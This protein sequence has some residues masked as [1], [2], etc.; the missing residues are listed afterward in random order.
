MSA[1][2]SSKNLVVQ[3]AVCRE[4]TPAGNSVCAVDCAESAAGLTPEDDERRDVVL[5]DFELAD[6][7]DKPLREESVRPHVSV[8]AVTPDRARETDELIEIAGFVPLGDALEA[9][10]R[11][12]QF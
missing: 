11:I 7:V 6:D 9:Q 8:R 3:D 4:R 12:L 10:R 1:G 5:L 2:E